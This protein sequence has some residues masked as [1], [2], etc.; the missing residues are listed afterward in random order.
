MCKL[1][2]KAK[3]N[4]YYKARLKA[5]KYND[6]LKSREGA[7]ELLH[8]NQATLAKYE[9]ETLN[10]PNDMVVL[11]ADL[12]NAPELLNWY[13]CNECSIGNCTK[14]EIQLKDLALVSLQILSKLEPIEEKKK[15][16]IHISADGK[17]D[18]HEKPIMK[19]VIDYFSDIRKIIDELEL[20]MKKNIKDKRKSTS[21]HDVPLTN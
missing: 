12:Y 17:I 3:D 15:K 14:E 20:W 2:T 5:S 6:R 13:C 4:V 11:M 7:A 19:E 9:L 1:A 21:L 16:L 18:E 8:I 10:V